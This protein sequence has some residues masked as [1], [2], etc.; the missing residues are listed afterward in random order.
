MTRLVDVARRAGVSKSTASNV[1]RGSALVA[2]P[3]RQR[4]ERAI[5]ETAY[6]PNAIARSLKARSSKAIGMLVPDLTNPFHAELV[7]SVE[8][9][10]SELGYAVLAVH[11]DCAPETEAEA[12]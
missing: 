10:A 5:A 3:T 9:A 8:R 7:V 11:T 4:V 12:C 6:L 1:I 2:D